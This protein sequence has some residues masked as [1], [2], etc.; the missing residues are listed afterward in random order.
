[1]QGVRV[2]L[3]GD[4]A[5]LGLRFLEELEDESHDIAQYTIKVV[6]DADLR[7]RWWRGYLLGS[8]FWMMDHWE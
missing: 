4:G 2:D 7:S 6:F 5:F 1:L 8:D 3:V